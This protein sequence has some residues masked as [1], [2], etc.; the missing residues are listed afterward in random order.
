M[1]T[2]LNRIGTAARLGGGVSDVSL[3][4]RPAFPPHPT[5]PPPCWFC[6]SLRN[7][8]AVDGW[9]ATCTWRRRRVLHRLRLCISL[10]RHSL[11]VYYVRLLF[12]LCVCTTV[13]RL[14]V[15][16]VGWWCGFAGVMCAS[17]H[18]CVTSCVL[19][20]CHAFIISAFIMR[21]PSVCLSVGGK[22]GPHGSG[23]GR[24]AA[25]RGGLAG[26]AA[27]LAHQPLRRRPKERSA[28]LCLATQPTAAATTA[29][30]LLEP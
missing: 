20:S 17:V 7:C 4:V 1:A 25:P 16:C 6:C 13:R 19:R 28:C 30:S 3:L 27:A 9:A 11:C 5:P 21:R 29:S 8:L 10:A 22:S 14:L 23:Q 24:S 18:L 26:G 2:L 12:V 15:V